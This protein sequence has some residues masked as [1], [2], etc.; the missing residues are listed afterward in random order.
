MIALILLGVFL[1]CLILIKIESKGGNHKKTDKI[2]TEEETEKINNKLEENPIEIMENAMDVDTS[3]EAIKKRQDRLFKN[4]SEEDKK[5]F[6]SYIQNNIRNP[7][8]D[9]EKKNKIGEDIQNRIV[10]FLIFGTICCFIYYS[11]N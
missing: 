8:N 6:K 4:F 9:N 11:L 10:D 7:K 1:G 2:I 3:E 5:N